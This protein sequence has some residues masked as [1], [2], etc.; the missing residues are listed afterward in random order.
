MG[1]G[2]SKYLLPFAA[3]SVDADDPVDEDEDVSA[4]ITSFGQTVVGPLVS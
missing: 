2:P 4:K 3:A 1:L